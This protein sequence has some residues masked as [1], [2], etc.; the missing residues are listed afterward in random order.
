MPWIARMS[1]TVLA[2]VAAGA[3]VW[4]AMTDQADKAAVSCGA[5]VFAALCALAFDD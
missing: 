5:F 2:S 1:F 4:G 3:A